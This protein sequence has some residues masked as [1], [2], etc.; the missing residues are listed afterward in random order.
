MSVRPAPLLL[1][2]V[3][4]LALARPAPGEAVLYLAAVQSDGAEVRCKPGT[5]PSVYVTHRLKR[6]DTVQVVEKAADGW[7]KVVPPKGSYSWVNTRVLSRADGPQPNWT[8][9]AP[10][11]VQVPVLVGSPFKAGRPDVVGTHLTRGAQVTAV[12]EPRAAE[13]GDGLWLPIMPPPGE[14]RYVREKDVAATASPASGTAAASTVAHPGSAVTS[15]DAATG[16]PAPDIHVGAPLPADDPLLKQAEEAERAGNRPEAARLY[17]QLGNKYADAHHDVAMQYYNRAAWLRGGSARPSAPPPVTPADA[18]YQQAR[19]YEQAGNRAEAARAYARLGDL[20]RDSDYKLAMQYYNRAALLRQGLPATPDA[21]LQP[22][23]ADRAGPPTGTCAPGPGPG[24]VRAVSVQMLGPGRL[25]RA[26]SWI[27][28]RPTYLLETPQAQVMAYLVPQP[29]V[30][31]E[32]YVG[33][34][35]EVLGQTV[36]RADVRGPYMTVARV[37]PLSSP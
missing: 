31:L 19:Q 33:Q 20:Y 11:R 30:D 4:A 3:L 2:T 5:E 32:H 12:G 29:G 22:V 21:R 24:P 16:R 36:P 9:V 14:Y 23:P 35:V 25:M 7:L 18:L 6:G 10:D 17:D 1:G 8:V 15:P 26:A 27:D 34:N 28:T 37:R 13:D